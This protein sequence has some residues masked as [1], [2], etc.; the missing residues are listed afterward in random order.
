MDTNLPTVCLYCHG[1][2]TQ[3]TPDGMTFPC[4]E[5]HGSG[6]LRRK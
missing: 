5:C 2:G 4:A 1:T 3:Q 6:V